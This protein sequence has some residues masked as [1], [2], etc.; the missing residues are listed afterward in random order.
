MDRGA[1]PSLSLHSVIPQTAPDHNIPPFAT[2]RDAW[3][4][5]DSGIAFKGIHFSRNESV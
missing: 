4:L 5:R 3:I 2:S 1:R